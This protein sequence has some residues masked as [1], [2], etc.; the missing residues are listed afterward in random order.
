MHQCCASNSLSPGFGAGYIT[1]AEDWE[2][3]SLLKVSPIAVEPLI[4]GSN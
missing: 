2:N 3:L 4:L 1:G